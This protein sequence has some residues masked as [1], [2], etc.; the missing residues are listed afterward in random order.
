MFWLILGWL[1]LETANW[2]LNLWLSNNVTIPNLAIALSFA[3]VVLSFLTGGFGLGF[4]LGAAVFS[5][6]DWPIVGMW[7]KKRRERSRNKDADETL[8]QE[9]DEI[10]QELYENAAHIERI[11]NERHWEIPSG[12]ISENRYKSWVEARAA[13]GREEE[14]IRRK[15]GHRIQI[16]FVKLQDR[17]IKMD[18]WGFSLSHY[19]LLSSSY[20][21]A[22]I[23]NSLRTGNYLEKEFKAG[24]SGL[25]TRM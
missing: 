19:D 2:M 20:F 15:L 17:S 21:F 16:I 9:C 8:A 10:S 24:H 1:T 13:E 6:W 5:A 11:R 7:I 23:A 18:L 3:K 22:D 14:R 12:E 4:V 25:P